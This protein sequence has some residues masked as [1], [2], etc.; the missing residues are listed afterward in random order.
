[1]TAG[2]TEINFFDTSAN[3][4]GEARAALIERFV[5]NETKVA[6][7]RQFGHAYFDDPSYGVGYGGY[8]YD[9][10]YK[11]NVEKMVAH[12]ALRPGQR[13]LEIGCA[14][15]FVLCEFRKLGF[16]VRGVDTSAYAV[17][18]AV[19]E[20]R[21]FV[22][23]RSCVELPF[24]DASFDLVYSKET[25]PHLSVAELAKA[26]PEIKRV[27]KS[28]NMFLELQTA[29]TDRERRLI[30]SWDETHQTVESAQWWR[31]FLASLDFAG[32][33]HFKRLFP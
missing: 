17:S 2:L 16:E 18:Q 3:R 20:V 6:D 7:F 11:A 12:Y 28:A 21:E 13:V 32:Q 22:V 14:K 5:P 31:D 4:R 8:A 25:L 1:M 29:E 27:A 19:P 24:E 30:R 33:V 10:R 15:G 9:G 26:I 23:N